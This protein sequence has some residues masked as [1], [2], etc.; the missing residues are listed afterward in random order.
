[1]VNWFLLAGNEPEK[2][3]SLFVSFS[4]ITIFLK[5]WHYG[6]GKKHVG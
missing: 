3:K 2:L 6:N 1:M 5:V 4:L